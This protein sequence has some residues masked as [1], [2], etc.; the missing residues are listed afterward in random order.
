MACKQTSSKVASQ[1]SKVLSDS[2]SSKT[3]KAVA[4]SALGQKECGS[5][6]SCAKK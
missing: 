6:K 2:K 1:A 5:K 3:E 4:G